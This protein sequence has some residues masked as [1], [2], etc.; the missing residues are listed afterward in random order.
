[1][2]A[3][4]VWRFPADSTWPT[5]RPTPFLWR[6]CA[7]TVIV[8]TAAI[9][10]FRSCHIHLGCPR[11]R[12]GCS[13]RRTR[14]ATS[15]SMKD[16]STL[17]RRCYEILSR[18][19][20]QSGQ[21]LWHCQRCREIERWTCPSQHKRSPDSLT[22]PSVMRGDVKRITTT[23]CQQVADGQVKRGG[24]PLGWVKLSERNPSSFSQSISRRLAPCV[25]NP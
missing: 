20:K 10:C 16:I 23:R 15:R 25:P 1:M 7:G 13:P 6:H 11:R 12:G 2:R 14:C 5:T 19:P 17:M 24:E 18:L 22:T 21:R 9:W 3:T 8:R 4:K